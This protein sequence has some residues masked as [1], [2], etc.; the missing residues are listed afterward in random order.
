MD[1][2]CDG[3]IDCGDVDCDLDPACGGGECVPVTNLSC[4][5]ALGARNDAPGSTQQVD[6]YSCLAGYT[7]S[8]PEIAGTFVAS[9]SGQV[10]VRVDG[11]SAD[12]DLF[13][14]RP[15]ANGTCDP[16]QC[17]DGSWAGGSSP[18]EVS[19][20]ATAGQTYYLVVDGWNGA[21]SSFDVSI[22]CG[23]TPP[24]DCENGVD[25]DGDGLVDC[26]D[27][28]CASHPACGCIPSP[29]QCADGQDN[30]CDG[31]VDCD[32][33]DCAGDPACCVPSPEQCTD[34]QDN[35]CDGLVDCDD[36]DC[37]AHPACCVPSPEVCDDGQDNDCDGLVDCD[38]GDCA[39][40]PACCVPQP[41][42]CYDFSD[43]D[44]DGLVDCAD[45]DCAGVP[46]CACYPEVCDDGQDNDCDN[47]V[48]CADPD[49]A[50]DPD[51]GG[52]CSPEVCF[53]L[54]DNDC[55]G[56]T[57]CD[58]PDCSAHPLC[59]VCQPEPEICDDGV[60]NDCDNLVDCDDHDCDG[61]PACCQ[62][63]AEI[64]YDTEDNDCDGLIDCVD[65][66]CAGDMAC[67]LP[68]CLPF[69]LCA[70]LRDEDCDGLVDCADPD[71][72]GDAH[73]AT[74][75]PYEADCGNYDDDDCDGAI[76]CADDD[77]ASSPACGGQA[78]T[79]Q[80][81]DW[82]MCGDVIYG[83]N[84]GVGHTDVL[85][86]YGCGTGGESGPEMTYVVE[87][88]GFGQVQ[89]HLEG[90]SADLDLFV[91]ENDGLACDPDRCL[92]QSIAGGT[93]AE[94]IT[95]QGAPGQTWYVVVDGWAGN[96]SDFELSVQCGGWQP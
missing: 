93:S 89:I 96:V 82:L 14:L 72:A 76:D 57:D 32:D 88:T 64:C 29:E 74:C 75:D 85:E 79:C 84:G 54:N 67:D 4:N 83:N 49:C 90:L 44:C 33:P 95:L 38:D 9:Q 31:L 5:T 25:D 78:N 41:E 6:S 70:S 16:N 39:L 77:C 86:D 1:N 30:D 50:S 56:L 11:L 46:G 10:T 71:C 3:L 40:D 13:V 37:D 15:G 63:I 19:F 80:P 23:V 60:D 87:M 55:D 65:P 36:D 28:D 47:L 12:L 18:E 73:C 51:C 17:L 45:L 8:G 92:E 35:D 59:N 43:N 27:G 91:L 34:G 2:D 66:D 68:F 61:A 52:T 69:E 48:D 7:W 20:F 24:E 53:D 62:P 26:A 22:Q 81:Q 42:D 94:Q 58:D 21:V